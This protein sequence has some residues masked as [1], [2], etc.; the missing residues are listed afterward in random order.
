MGR[1]ALGCVGLADRAA[2]GD[3]GDMFGPAVIIVVL[4]VALPVAVIMSGA[5]AAAILGFFLKDEVE[6]SHE[7]SELV[8]TNR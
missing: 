4:V 7:G 8:A 3:N 2:L 6:R 5:V 1:A